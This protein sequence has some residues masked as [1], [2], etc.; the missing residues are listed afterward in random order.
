MKANARQYA[1]S[2]TV[3][4]ASGKRSAEELVSG[5]MTLLRK[6]KQLPA[7][8]KILAHLQEAEAEKA[9]VVEVIIETASKAEKATESTLLAEAEKIY[10]GVKVQ[11]TFIVQPQ[12][13]H[14]FRIRGKNKQLDQRFTSKLSQLRHQLIQP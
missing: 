8:K 7:A 2:L 1:E 14:G 13:G 9:G 3:A 11:A 12:L 5:L 4:H 10:P 6:K